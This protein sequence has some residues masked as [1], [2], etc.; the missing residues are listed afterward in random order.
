MPRLFLPKP[1]FVGLSLTFGPLIGLYL[2]TGKGIGDAS[3]RI[4]T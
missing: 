3:P 4:D 2:R 1:C